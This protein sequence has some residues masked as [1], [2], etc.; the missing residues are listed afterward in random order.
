MDEDSA[1]YQIKLP[2]NESNTELLTIVELSDELGQLKN[3]PNIGPVEKR[4]IA[5]IEDKFCKLFHQ[6]V[7]IVDI[8]EYANHRPGDKTP[9]NPECA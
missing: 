7:G 1:S 3:S 4:K 2:K 8:R 5:T 9:L 6:T